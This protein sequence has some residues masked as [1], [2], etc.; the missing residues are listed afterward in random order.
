M[1]TTQTEAKR[2]FADR[3]LRQAKAEGVSMSEAER[4]MLLWSESDPD[5]TPNLVLAQTL[6]NE[7]SDEAYEAKIVGLLTRSFAGE[8]AADP[9]ASDVWQRAQS[10]LNQ[11]DHYI[12]IMIDRS[13]GSKLKPWWRFW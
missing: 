11:G 3:V 5:F 7:M 6:N 13:I 8:I 4:H 10:V 1:V 12:A 2:F 9:G